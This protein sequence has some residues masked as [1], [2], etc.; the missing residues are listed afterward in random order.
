VAVRDQ[1]DKDSN[2]RFGQI[3]GRCSK[4][5]SWPILLKNSILLQ[6]QILVNAQCISQ[7]AL[8]TVEVLVKWPV[9][10]RN[11]E[12]RGPPHLKMRDASMG[13]EFLVQV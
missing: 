10:A 3:F 1:R 4:D 5:R 8:R 12:L 2:V 13:L 6:P 9:V 7:S 11:T